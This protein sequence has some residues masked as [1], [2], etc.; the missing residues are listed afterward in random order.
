MVVIVLDRGVL[1]VLVRGEVAEA[2]GERGEGALG[3]VGDAEPA[4]SAWVRVRVWCVSF[5]V[6]VCYACMR[7]AVVDTQ[8]EKSTSLAREGRTVEER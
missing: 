5:V 7:A 4:W 2:E 8:E 3:Q 6:C 1:R